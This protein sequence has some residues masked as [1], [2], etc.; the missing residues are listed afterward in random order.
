M[1]GGS[2]EQDRAGAAAM[3]EDLPAMAAHAYELALRHCRSCANYHIYWAARRAAGV[4]GG[5]D[6]GRRDYVAILQRQFSSGAGDI[7]IAGAA[8]TGI[9]SA[10]AHGALAAGALD[11]VKFLVVDRCRTPLLLCEDF[12]IRRGIV[13]E[14][15]R[16]DLTAYK[17]NRRFD[18]VLLHSTLAF[19]PTNG[20]VAMMRRLA[21]WLSPRGRII[22][23]GNVGQPS[24]PSAE[25][26]FQERILPKLK[27]AIADG[28]LRLPESEDVFLRRCRDRHDGIS[29]DRACFSDAADILR[30]AA[31]AGLSVEDGHFAD[32]EGRHGGQTRPQK[33]SVILSRV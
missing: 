17:T 4:I 15:A 24:D 2:G 22:L 10:A 5:A 30:L 29:Y 21:D 7:L 33:Y 31:D 13:I 16:A 32:R 12:G 18:L 27:V 11:S 3:D 19:C 8:D 28:R 25:L 6:E 26:R 9:L 20:R 23:S 1:A 14:T